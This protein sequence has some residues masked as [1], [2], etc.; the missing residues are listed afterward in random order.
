MIRLS[1]LPSYQD[2]YESDPDIKAIN[3]FLKNNKVTK[4]TLENISN[5]EQI[6]LIFDCFPRLQYFALKNLINIDLELALERTSLKINANKI[7]HPMKFPIFAAEAECD[8]LQ[9]LKQTIE[10]KKLLKNFTIHRQFNRFDLQ[11][12]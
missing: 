8:K 6:N 3:Q 1:E 11:W 10:S 2:I 4:L 12:K 9:K 5:L 7:F